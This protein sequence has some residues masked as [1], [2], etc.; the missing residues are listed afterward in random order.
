M[1][2]KNYTTKISAAQTM[3]EIQGILATHGARKVMMDFNEKG[4]AE[5]VTFA[6]LLNGQILGFRLMAKPEGVVRV[7]KKDGQ[8]CTQEQATR[9]AWRNIKDWIAAQIALVE[10]EQASMQELFL[11]YLI[12][13]KN[14]APPQTLYEK[15][16]NTQYMLP[17]S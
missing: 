17:E 13:S 16:E 7:M 11:P 4:E 2:I 3:G 12:I 1:P 14:D 9:I 8:N 10:T 5:A 15:F 6:L